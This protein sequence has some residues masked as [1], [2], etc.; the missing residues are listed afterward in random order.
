MKSNSTTKKK[1]FILFLLILF[2]LTQISA[3][4]LNNYQVGDYS[5]RMTLSEIIEK[6]DTLSPIDKNNFLLSEKELAIYNNYI[7]GHNLE[8]IAKKFKSNKE[9]IRQS[10]ISSAK[11]IY[12]EKKFN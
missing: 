8:K 5:Y 9:T 12:P 10:L 2:S 7:Q 1:T 6:W 11:K 3:Q 4:F